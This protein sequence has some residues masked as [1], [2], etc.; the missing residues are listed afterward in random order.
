LGTTTIESEGERIE[1]M[2]RELDEKF[3]G[4][5]N[6]NTTPKKKRRKK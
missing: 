4:K 3:Y 6:T 1:R 5:P 2:K